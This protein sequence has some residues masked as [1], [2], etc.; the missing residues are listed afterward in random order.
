MSGRWLLLAVVIGVLDR[1]QQLV[2]FGFRYI[3]SDEGIFWQAVNDYAHGRLHE[4]FYYGQDY[5]VMTE[6]FA[7]VPLFWAGIPLYIALPL[8]TALL[9]LLPFWS[10]GWWLHRQGRGVAA[11]AVALLPVLLPVEYGILVS[12]PRGFVGGCAV[13]A[14]WPWCLSVE[15][16]FLRGAAAGAVLALAVFLN[17]NA[18]LFAGPVSLLF[19]W[20][21]RRSLIAWLGV[22]VGAL[23][24]AALWSGAKAFMQAH[25]ERV[26]HTIGEWMLV[27]N[28]AGISE[29]FGQL[30]KHFAWLMPL[31][32]SQGGLVLLLLVLVLV[33]LAFRRKWMWAISLAMVLVLIV[34]SFGYAKVHDGVLHPFFAWS[35]MFLAVP[36]VVAWWGAQALS[37]QGRVNKPWSAAGL[38]VLGLI[39][40]LIKFSATPAVVDQL[41][42]TQH[43]A[44]VQARPVAEIRTACA[45]IAKVA[46]DNKVDL[47]VML[48]PPDD[49]TSYV[50]C[51]TCELFEPDMPY[52]LGLEY[53]RRAWR[54]ELLQ[55]PAP[56]P[57]LVVGGT[58][59]QAAQ[60]MRNGTAV[61]MEAEGVMLHLLSPVEQPLGVRLSELGS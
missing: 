6:A 8:V 15:R 23:P 49:F 1:L 35:R 11:V 37:A 10:M 17:P 16:P 21:H 39:M 28:K 18:L 13:L 40:G 55:R 29:A 5:T 45:A 54:R 22:L 12:Q 38:V 25:P 53:D 3:G 7:A 14:L 9:S 44:P 48:K 24:V 26:K 42:A 59:E 47:V 41:L 51:Y 31:W 36:L 32:W 33:G 57:V 61:R 60:W 52:T 19:A 4:P 20:D 27:F 46:R 58:A 2:R 34:R 30:N 43:E 50:R 56:G